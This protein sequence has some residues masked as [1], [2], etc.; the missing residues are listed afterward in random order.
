MVV[1]MNLKILTIFQKKFY[2]WS[3][4]WSAIIQT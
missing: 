3:G 4:P 1:K 2:I